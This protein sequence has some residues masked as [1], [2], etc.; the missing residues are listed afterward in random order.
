MDAQILINRDLFCRLVD[1]YALAEIQLLQYQSTSPEAG[2]LVA[3]RQTEFDALR[4]LFP[5]CEKLEDFAEFY[6][7]LERALPRRES[8]PA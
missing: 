4:G 5:K 8:A 3:Q 2:A 6:A 7:R 1:R